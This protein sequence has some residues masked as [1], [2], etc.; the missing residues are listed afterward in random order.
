MQRMEV[1]DDCPV[2]ILGQ[3]TWRMEVKDE[4]IDVGDKNLLTSD[5]QTMGRW[6]GPVKLIVCLTP[7]LFFSYHSDSEYPYENC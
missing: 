4:S 7:Q 3:S 5:V 1:D 6:A 2:Q